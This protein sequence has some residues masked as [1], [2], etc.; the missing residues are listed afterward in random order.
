VVVVE[1]ERLHVDTLDGQDLAGDGL[2]GGDERLARHGR[3]SR[4]VQLEVGGDERLERAAVARGDRGHDLAL[5]LQELGGQGLAVEARDRR[6]PGGTG[7]EDEGDGE[8]HE[9]A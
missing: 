7:G 4:H 3:L 8:Q 2:D 6:G 5:G 1:H 9:R